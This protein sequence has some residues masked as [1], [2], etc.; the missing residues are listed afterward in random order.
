[1]NAVDAVVPISVAVIT[2]AGA[3]VAGIVQL[4]KLRKENTE[5]HATAVSHIEQTH[6][7]ISDMHQD[8][9]D[10]RD[11]V[12]QVRSDLDRHLGE[13]EAMQPYRRVK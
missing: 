4:V 10:I 12:Q 9:R 8:V 6:R 7:M 1:M 2:A 5:Q 11:D 3:S 13:H